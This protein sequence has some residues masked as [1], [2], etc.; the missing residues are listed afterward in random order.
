MLSLT[1]A[2]NG[3]TTEMRP[4]SKTP[5]Q[6]CSYTKQV[7]LNCALGAK[8]D[9]TV[10]TS[11][12]PLELMAFWWGNVPLANTRLL[13]VCAQRHPCYET[14][15][16]VSWD[17]SFAM[18]LLV[19]WNPIYEKRNG[20]SGQQFLQWTHDYI[21]V[22]WVQPTEIYCLFVGNYG[23]E[24]QSNSVGVMVTWQSVVGLY[25]TIMAVHTATCISVCP[26]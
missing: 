26:T 23:T 18:A 16:Q 19:E 14:F 25:G 8:H 13:W 4:N 22:G 20:H 17:L 5:F 24:W 21:I 7:G 12:F 15:I 10:K 9:G 3:N 2:L 6:S 11:S 1:C